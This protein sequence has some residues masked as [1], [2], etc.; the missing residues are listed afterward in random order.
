MAQ[1]GGF[2]PGSGRPVGGIGESR[3]LL[4]LAIKRGL[5]DAVRETGHRG[6]DDDLAAAG[7]AAIVQQMI[8]SGQGDRVLAIWSQ[9][10]PKEEPRANGGSS[11]GND[12]PLAS[13]LGRMPGADGAPVAHLPGAVAGDDGASAGDAGQWAADSQ[14]AGMAGEGRQALQDRDQRDPQQGQHDQHQQDGGPLIGQV[15]LPGQLVLGVDAG[16]GALGPVATFPRV[17]GRAG[18][19]GCAPA[20][21]RVPA[22]APACECVPGRAGTP[23]P[24]PAQPREVIHPHGSNFDFGSE[25][26]CWSGDEDPDEH[27]NSRDAAVV[28][29]VTRTGAAA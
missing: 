19:C 25:D 12:S 1:V 26:E 8:R 18:L 21:E 11:S 29:G 28:V 2:R 7:A 14:S 15:L 13:A 4:D 10:A 17:S 16:P 3:R 9:V 23:T 24:P 20:P 6:N 5:A 22:G 27:D